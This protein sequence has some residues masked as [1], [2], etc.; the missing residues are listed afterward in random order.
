MLVATHRPLSSSFL[1]L[2]YRILDINHKRMYL[3]AYGYVMIHDVRPFAM[4]LRIFFLLSGVDLS[5]T[6]KLGR[7]C[8]PCLSTLNP[9]SNLYIHT[10]NYGSLVRGPYRDRHRTLDK[11]NPH[12]THRTV[13]EPLRN[14]YSPDKAL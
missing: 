2:P 3:G 7:T 1:G 8:A 10:L 4:C 13:I 9:C 6:P 12:R 14:L 11:D 5:E